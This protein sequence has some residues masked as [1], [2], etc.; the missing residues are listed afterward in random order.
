MYNDKG[1]YVFIKNGDNMLIDLSDI[2]SAEKKEKSVTVPIEFTEIS[3]QG[4][5]YP[6]TASDVKVEIFNKGKKKLLIQMEFQASIKIPCDRCLEDVVIE[7]PVREEKVVDFNFL[8]TEE[9]DDQ[10]EFNFMDGCNLDVD[11]LAY[12]EISLAI[13]MKVLCKEDCKGICSVCGC[14]RNHVSCDCDT[15]VPDPRMSAI[16]DIFN[17]FKEV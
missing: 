2:L 7:V 5:Q 9:N 12:G 15:T 16:Y 8:K 17:N 10:D 11:M 3:Y 1:A 13:P 14:N 6:V 4:N